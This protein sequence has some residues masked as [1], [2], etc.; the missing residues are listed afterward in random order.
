MKRALLLLAIASSGCALQAYDPSRLPRYDYSDYYYYDVPYGMSPGSSGSKSLA[1]VYTLQRRES[2][3]WSNM[4]EFE[5]QSEALAALA[6]K[7]KVETGRAWR[8]LLVIGGQEL[9]MAVA[10]S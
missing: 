3:G 8:I 1:P 10:K 4:G 6:A 2:Y 5:T 9:L 7:S